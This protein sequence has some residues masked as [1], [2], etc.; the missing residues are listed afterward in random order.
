MIIENDELEL[1]SS[2][3]KSLKKTIQQL[4]KSNSHSK[5]YTNDE[6]PNEIQKRIERLV[7]GK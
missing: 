4:E 5:E 2:V 6:M 1:D 7:D 3:L